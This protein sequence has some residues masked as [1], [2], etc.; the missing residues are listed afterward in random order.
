MSTEIERKFIVDKEKLQLSDK[1]VHITQGYLSDNA[2][3]SVRVRIKEDLAY[4]TIKN[5]EDSITRDEFDYE[6]KLEDAKWILDN[7][8]LYQS[9]EKIRYKICFNGNN[10]MVDIFKGLNDGLVIAEI[11]LNCIDNEIEFP[12]WIIEEVTGNSQYYNRN[13]AKY[14]YSKWSTV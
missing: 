10:W 1:C 14:P 5:A 3:N 6:I 4:L 11:E 2:I 8:C 13:L 9:I 7:L 12:E